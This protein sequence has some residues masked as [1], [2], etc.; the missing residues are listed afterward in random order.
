LPTSS[1][2]SSTLFIMDCQTFG[3]FQNQKL[4]KLENAR[5]MINNDQN[6]D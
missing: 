1:Q 2:V 4:L 3:I 5:E 6:D